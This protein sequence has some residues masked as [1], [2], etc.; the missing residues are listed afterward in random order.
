MVWI[1]FWSTITAENRGIQIRRQ[2]WLRRNAAGDSGNVHLR[3]TDILHVR[4]HT[5]RGLAVDCRTPDGDW[6]CMG[7]HR[8]AMTAQSTSTQVHPKVL[9]AEQEDV[10]LGGD[11]YG[12]QQQQH[13]QPQEQDQED[14]SENQPL[15]KDLHNFGNA[16][17]PRPPL[18]SSF[19]FSAGW[20]RQEITWLQIEVWWC[21]VRRIR[22][23]WPEELLEVTVK[24]IEGWESVE[25]AIFQGARNGFK[26]S[27]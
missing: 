24:L 5:T 16:S 17:C 2:M 23:W 21:R 22:R 14:E 27:E 6:A 7:S 25:V 12:M 9:S 20:F 19:R 15:P 11:N 4:Q 26:N 3:L 8:A 1:S 10:M 13:Q 18:A